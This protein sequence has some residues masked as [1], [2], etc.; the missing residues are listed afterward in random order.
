MHAADCILP[1]EQAYEELRQCGIKLERLP[2]EYRINYMFG[3]EATA[4]IVEQLEDALMQG[5]AMAQQLEPKKK[6]STRQIVALTYKTKRRLKILAHNHRAR[7][8]W[9][10]QHHKK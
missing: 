10:K 8:L 5:R 7:G 9:L 3:G 1:F 6:S 2:G 4:R